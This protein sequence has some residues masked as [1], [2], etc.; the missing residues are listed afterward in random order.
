MVDITNYVAMCYNDLKAILIREWRKKSQAPFDEDIFHDTLLNCLDKFPND[1]TKTIQ[2]FQLYVRKAFNMNFFRE[3][4]YHRNSKDADINLE[5]INQTVTVRF[6]LDSELILD[7]VKSKYP[8]VQYLQFKDWMDGYT[9]MELNKKYE[10]LNA[11]Y[12]IDI[13]KQDVREYFE[14]EVNYTSLKGGASWTE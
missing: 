1:D 9:I 13:I 4:A 2:D 10:C 14:S 12:H 11:R 5:T 8:E 7:Y 6:T 3:K